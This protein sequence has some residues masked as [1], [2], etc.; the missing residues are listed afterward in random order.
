MESCFKLINRDFF[1][2]NKNYLKMIKKLKN[3][4]NGKSQKE[5]VTII[6]KLR[7]IR[8]NIKEL[9]YK[10]EDF[11]DNPTLIDELHLLELKQEE[12]L[13]DIIKQI[14]FAT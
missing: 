9:T 6:D 11:N 3:L 13:M 12:R 14:T 4:L 1:E 2:L 7:L 8:K 10:L 5:K